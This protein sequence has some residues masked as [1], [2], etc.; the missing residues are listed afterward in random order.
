MNNR[1]SVKVATLF[2]GVI[3]L[4]LFVQGITQIF[5]ARTAAVNMVTVATLAESRAKAEE[6]GRWLQGHLNEAA[7]LASIPLVKSGKSEEI[8]EYMIGRQGALNPDHSHNVYIDP[9]GMNYSSRGTSNDISNR[10]YFLAIMRDRNRTFIDQPIWSRSFNQGQFMVNHAVENE[11]G[12]FTGMI[13]IAVTLNTLMDIVS[14][15][16]NL[17]GIQRYIINNEAL[18]VAHPKQ[19]YSMNLNLLSAGE[20]GYQGLNS[21][22]ELMIQGNEGVGRYRDPQHGEIMAFFSPISF[23][24]DWTLVIAI[25]ETQVFSEIPVMIRTIV[26]I[27]LLLIIISIAISIYFA[28]SIS[29]PILGNIDRLRDTSNSIQGAADQVASSSQ[30]MAEGASLQASSLEETS[31]SLEELSSMTRRNNESAR[32]ANK[33]SE[34]ASNTAARGNESM[35]RLNQQMD[36]LK[37]SND[38]TSKIINA[39]DEIA[40]QTNLLSLNAAVEA[41]RAGEAGRGF[42]VVAEEV[43]RLALRTSEAAKETVAIIERSRSASTGGLSIAGEVSK[44]LA[45]INLKTAKVNEL[46]SEITAASMDQSQGLEQIN[47][48]MVH[49]DGVTQKNAEGA[50]QNASAA[51][52][53]KIESEHLQYIVGDL[54]KLI[55]GE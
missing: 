4:L 45:D 54:N 38:E 36:E 55:T 5:Q 15:D 24:P 34:E 19:E 52:N 14:S 43:R 25:P 18:V 28:G 7:L 47:R 51:S 1:F 41:A 17:T 9:Q 29:K 39:I 26:T 31:A 50:S 3:V 40:F 30:E 44:Y 32:E 11:A 10:D 22:A 46:V 16:L 37:K 23:S 33:L 12:E 27:S 21:L 53:L 49:I 35:G 20:L 8:W 6:V 13:S 2:G 42:A 48:A